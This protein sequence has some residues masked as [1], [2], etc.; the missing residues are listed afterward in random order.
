MEDEIYHQ[1]SLFSEIYDKKIIKKKEIRLIEFFAGIG[2]QHKA[3]S[4]LVKY[5]NGK[6]KLVSW[7]ICEW[8]FNSYCAYNS[9][10]IKDFN[11]YSKGKSLEEM[12]AKIKGTSTNYSEP[13][14]EKQLRSKSISWIKQAYNNIIATHN[15]VNI[16]EVKGG[17]LE[18]RDT[19]KYEYILTYSFPCQ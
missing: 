1:M 13:L 10:H 16:M 7:K 8:A 5:T 2:A 15:L 12:L 17:D 9:I 3:L 14:S 4:E 6:I 18:I 11:D 19:D